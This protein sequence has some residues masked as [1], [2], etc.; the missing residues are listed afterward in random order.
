M[1]LSERGLDFNQ[2]ASWQDV[3]ASRALSTTYTN[4]TGKMIIV[5]TRH[6]NVGNQGASFLIN[7]V[8]HYY[9]YAVLNVFI[10]LVPPNATYSVSAANSPIGFWKE[11]R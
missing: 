1:P 9:N 10:V 4:T 2:S 7:G 3:T 8:E 5:S 11:F 6:T